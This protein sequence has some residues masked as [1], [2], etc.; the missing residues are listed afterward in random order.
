MQLHIE[1]HHTEDSPFAVTD[2]VIPPSP[3]STGGADSFDMRRGYRQDE[4]DS[5]SWIKCTRPGCGEHILVMEID[6]HLDMHEAIDRSTADE[7]ESFDPRARNNGG[8]RTQSSSDEQTSRKSSKAGP[9][10]RTSQSPGSLLNYFK[11]K[12]TLASMAERPRKGQSLLDKQKTHRAGKPDLG[13]HAFEKE[14]PA[15][16]RNALIE[17]SKPRHINRIGSGMKVE[18]TFYVPNQTPDLIPIIAD[19]CSASQTTAITYLA[20]PAVCHISR[21]KCEGEFCGYWN[22]QMVYSG[23]GT[24]KPANN[25]ANVPNVLQIQRVIEDAWSKGICEVGRTQTGGILN[26][27]KWIGSIEAVAFFVNTN[28]HVEALFFK[29]LVS[30]LDYVEAYFASGLDTAKAYGSSR[31]TQLPA[32]YFQRRGHSMTCVGLEKNKDGTRTLLVFDPS[33]FTTEAMG[34]VIEGKS[35]KSPPESLLKPYRRNE[36]SLGRFSDFELVTP[37]ES[38]K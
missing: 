15:K 16:V 28:V 13:P 36:V 11:G 32:I 1:E 6:E 3:Q 19:L 33:W 21:I 38:S 26:S 4:R 23:I 31:I 37:I 27:R 34:R 9:L 2:P 30:M 5:P 12:P 25:I 29:S 17:D 8:K 18:P 10:A 24:K 20:S 7:G 14:M 35:V 22:I